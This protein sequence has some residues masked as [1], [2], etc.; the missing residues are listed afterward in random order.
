MKVLKCF[1]WVWLAIMAQ[2]LVG[3]SSDE[4]I[5]DEPGVEQGGSTDDDGDGKEDEEEA[6]ESLYRPFV[7]DKRISKLV[8]ER[9]ATINY[10]K[11]YS[12]T[13]YELSYDEKGR[14]KEYTHYILYKEGSKESSSDTTYYRLSYAKNTITKYADFGDYDDTFV[15]ELDENGYDIDKNI[16]EEGYQTSYWMNGHKDG[17]CN[18]YYENGNL[19]KETTP[20]GSY[21]Y[22]YTNYKN[23]ASLD[24]S[25]F[26]ASRD[27]DEIVEIPSDLYGKR[28][29]N[30]PDK[31]K[32]IS[33]SRIESYFTY[34]FDSKER[35]IE[36]EVTDSS[37]FHGDRVNN[38]Y[39]I[40]YED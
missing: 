5:E 11:E 34:K 1:L 31:K 40:T 4:P 22:T 17:T 16:N 30:L 14:V 6:P 13:T 28:S 33:S 24:I 15:T 3:C 27:G 38:I 37:D 29:V 8:K 23:D 19:V 39:H 9:I 20:I 21:E 18:L 36:I 35:V 10:R 26:L 2:T 7:T 32:T 12:Y 25:C